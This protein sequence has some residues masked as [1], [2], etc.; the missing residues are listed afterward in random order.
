MTSTIASA[1]SATVGSGRRLRILWISK[2]PPEH[3]APRIWQVARRLAARGHDVRVIAARTEHDLPRERALDG[4]RLRYVATAPRS[5]LR[6]QRFGFYAS[7]LPW[8]AVAGRAAAA[9]LR[10]E[11]ADVVVEDLSPV[12]GIGVDRA[13]RQFDVA[14]VQDVH[15]LLGSTVDWLRM[16]GPIGLWGGLYEHWLLGGRIRPDALVS[17]NAPLL[18]RLATRLPTI[19][20]TWIPNGIDLDRDVALPRPS[21][22]GRIHLLAVGRLATP[23]GHRVLI[24]SMAE[25]RDRDDLSLSIVGDGP[26]SAAL[27]EQIRERRVGGSVELVGR[28]P[29]DRLHEAYTGADIFVMPS[30]AEGLPIALVEA[31]GSGTAVIASDIPEHRQVAGDDAIAY[32]PVGDAHALAGAIRQLA[33]DAGRRAAMAV[34]GRRIVEQ[35]FTWEIVADQWERLLLDAASRTRAA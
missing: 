13:L 25:L 15:Y 20:L 28:V 3:R 29:W 30:L 22:N 34:T 12:G 18:A 27:A 26:L 11:P 17:D 4:V 16:Y 23:K 2:V 9:W 21:T 1:A 6:S 14:F 19:P 5:L 33:D 10:D 35:R 24:D 32:T 31:L 8:Y 7:R